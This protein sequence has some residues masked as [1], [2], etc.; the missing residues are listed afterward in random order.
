METLIIIVLAGLFG[1]GIYKVTKKTEI[2]KRTGNGGGG[3]APGGGWTP[4][5]PH[6]LPD[7]MPDE[8]R[9]RDSGGI[10]KML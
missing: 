7:N 5:Y 1:F 9:D 3:S 2:K 6:D 10:K 4:N 8:S